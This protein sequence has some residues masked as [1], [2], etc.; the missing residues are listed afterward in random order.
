M[1]NPNTGSYRMTTNYFIKL[2]TLKGGL[3]G[4]L[5]FMTGI[6]LLKSLS[7]SPSASSGQALCE[8]ERHDE[9]RLISPN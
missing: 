5:H 7:I 9:D 4:I 3:R 1:N 6:P 2:N 8:R